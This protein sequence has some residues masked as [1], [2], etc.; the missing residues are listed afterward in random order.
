MDSFGSST[1]QI[2]FI[3]SLSWLTT[4]SAAM[5]NRMMPV[6]AAIRP[7]CGELAPASMAST[8]WLP[9]SPNSDLN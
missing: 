1:F 9:V 6:A 5:S 7:L 8:A 3:A 2:V 4:P